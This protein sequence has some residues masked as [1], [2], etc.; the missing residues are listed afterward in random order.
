MLRAVATGLP[1]SLKGETGQKAQIPLAHRNT[2]S[3]IQKKFTTAEK[4]TCTPRAEQ[5]SM[6]MT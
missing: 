6:D 5:D 3:F 4:A 1:K 2:R